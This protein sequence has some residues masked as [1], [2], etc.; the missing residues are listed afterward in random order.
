[1]T[2]YVR[3]KDSE[4]LKDNIIDSLCKIVYLKRRED[5]YYIHI[6]SCQFSDMQAL[7]MNW[8]ELVNNVADVIQKRL[9]KIIEIYNIYII[10]FQPKIEESLVAKVEQNKYSSRKIV[11]AENMPENMSDLEEMI[12]IR[13]F[14][15]YIENNVDKQFC[16]KNMEFLGNCNVEEGEISLEK[17]I[18][19]LA[20]GEKY[21]KNK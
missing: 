9:D 12:D 7:E 8:E 3:M 16:I 13:L 17:Y 11:I 10:F 6:V 15:L 1:M 19:K 4:V 14:R 20:M 2:Q 5:G 18:T 21:E